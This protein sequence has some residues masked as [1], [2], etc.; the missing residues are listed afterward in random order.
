MKIRL[1]TSFL[2][3]FILSIFVLIISSA[4][5][6]EAQPIINEIMSLNATVL[7]DTGGD[8][9]DWIEIYNPDDSAVN[10]TGYGLSDDLDDPFKWVFPEYSLGAGEY[11][12]VYAS[13][14]DITSLPKH[15][16]T[17]IDWGDEL[18]YVTGSSDIAENWRSRDFD[19]S[20]WGTGPSGIGSMADNDATVVPQSI[21][22]TELKI[23]PKK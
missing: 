23:K 22:L 2:F 4:F 7:Q 20:G 8:Y 6:T 1:K 17:V 5:L 3:T 19:D 14:K 9:P 12:L 10:L 21:S 13:D 15:W 11:L 16:E 18:K